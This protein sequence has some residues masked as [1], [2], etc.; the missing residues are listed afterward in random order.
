MKTVSDVL[1]ETREEK[2][3]TLQEIS[4]EIKIRSSY[5]NALEEN[6]YDKF[7][8]ETQLKG[9]LVNY[10]NHLGIDTNRILALYRRERIAKEEQHSPKFIKEK[11]SLVF[12]PKMLLG[13]AIGIL[14]LMVIGFF[15][16]QYYQTAKA[17]LLEVQKPADGLVT[18]SNKITVSGISEIGSTIRVNSK[19][20]TPFDNNGNFE[21]TVELSQ[22]GNNTIFV[23]VENGFKKK[24][25]KS[26][27]VFYS[28]T[29]VAPT[30]TPI[31]SVTPGKIT[32]SIKSTVTKDLSYKVTIDGSESLKTLKA[33]A[34]AKYEGSK[35]IAIDGLL[36]SD[37]VITVNG[38]SIPLTKTQRTFTFTWDTATNTVKQQ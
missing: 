12:T 28:P 1:R 15:V 18:E 16:Y 31:P 26:I 14:V 29:E 8:S 7:L 6:D 24:T 35:N 9:F 2:G 17:P 37:I 36:G 23:E 25:T 19:E 4:E 5:L 10:A 13:P 3:K 38:V 27:N 11:K 21:T 20:I 34:E 22:K 32:I 30:A 33:Q